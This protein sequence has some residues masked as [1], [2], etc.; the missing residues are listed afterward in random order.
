MKKTYPIRKLDKI[1]KIQMVVTGLAFILFLILIIYYLIRNPLNKYSYM[2]IACIII[3]S[4]VWV[5]A[6][7]RNYNRDKYF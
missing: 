3:C 5:Y 6:F 7:Y 1:S 4:L 2:Y